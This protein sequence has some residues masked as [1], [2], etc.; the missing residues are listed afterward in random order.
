[1]MKKLLIIPLSIILGACSVSKAY[2]QYDSPRINVVE[3][4]ERA[5]VSLH[6]Y[7]HANAHTEITPQ[8]MA[9]MDRY[10]GQAGMLRICDHNRKCH[11]AY[12]MKKIKINQDYIEIIMNDGMEV[13]TPNP[14]E[15]VEFIYY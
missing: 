11:L 15:A 14:Y 8:M 9:V 10:I 7:M 4:Q 2:V 6:Q 5:F 13:R 3:Q 1:M 12:G